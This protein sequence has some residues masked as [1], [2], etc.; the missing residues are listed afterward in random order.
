MGGGGGGSKAG[1]WREKGRVQGRVCLPGHDPAPGAVQREFPPVVLRVVQQAL[2]LQLAQV[3][4]RQLV[5]HDTVNCL[6]NLTFA[7]CGLKSAILKHTY[8]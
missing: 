6:L 2:H 8:R 4:I 3:Q 5:K 7:S 1:G